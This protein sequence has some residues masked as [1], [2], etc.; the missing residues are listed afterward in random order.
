MGLNIEDMLNKS[1]DQYA[2][3][4]VNLDAEPSA[5]TLRRIGST[6]GVLSVRLLAAVRSV[7]ELG[8][9][10]DLPT[11]PGLSLNSRPPETAALT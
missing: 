11:Q 6:D 10:A 2:D 4:I 3:T 5:D 9:N 1:R 7:E 8:A